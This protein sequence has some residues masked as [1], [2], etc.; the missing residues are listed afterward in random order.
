MG[1]FDKLKAYAAR[2]SLIEH[3]L[4]AHSYADGTAWPFKDKTTEDLE[5]LHFSLSPSCKFTTDKRLQK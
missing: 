2:L 4:S 3:L 1:F 5:W